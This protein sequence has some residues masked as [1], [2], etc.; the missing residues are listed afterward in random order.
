VRATATDEAGNEA[1]AVPV[2]FRV[3][4]EAVNLRLDTPTEGLVTDD[5][6]PP[7]TG[8][9]DPGATV[10]L[11]IRD[12]DGNVVAT[13][14]PEVDENGSFAWN[15][16]PALADGPYVAHAEATGENGLKTEVSVN[17]T[18][19]TTTWVTIARPTE[20]AETEEVRPE[21]GG[22]AEPGATVTVSVDGIEVGVATADSEGNWSVTPT[23]DLAEGEHTVMAVATDE[24]GNTATA[25][26]TFTIV[27]PENPDTNPEPGPEVGP[28]PQP[29]AGAETIDPNDG[30]V[31]MGGAGCEGGGTTSWLWA[32]AALMALVAARR[33]SQ[34]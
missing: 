23:A 21:L 16:D 2:G 18:V 13:F 11:T 26:S 17:F 34:S 19:D 10:V 28:E 3:D 24:A 29:D 27:V 20:G 15:V 32:L 31:A 12:A 30:V 9:T 25:T 8:A 4:S 1:E 33:R 6:T 14:A 22:T 7:V 5:T